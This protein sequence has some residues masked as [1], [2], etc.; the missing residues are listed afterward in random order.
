M[1]TLKEIVAE[2]MKHINDPVDWSDYGY[3]SEEEYIQDMELT[4]ADW[5]Q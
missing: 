3:E 2:Q 4:T 5:L 1:K